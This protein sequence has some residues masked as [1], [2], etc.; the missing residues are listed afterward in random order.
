MTAVAA[1]APTARTAPPAT[2]AAVVVHYRDAASTLRCVESLRRQ[3]PSPWIVV[4]DNASPDGSGGQLAAAL[5]EVAGTVVLHAPHNGGFG[6][7]CNRGIAAALERLPTL[8]HV[9]LL[10]PD[11][12]L[13]DGA[14]ATLQATQRRRDADVVGCRVVDA[15]RAP[16][17]ENGRIPRWTLAGFHAPADARQEHPTAFVTGA[18]MLLA[19]RTLRAGLRFDER[20]FLYC[21]DAD[22]C[23]QV[24]A[25]GGSVWLTRAARAV[26]IG[27]GS[28]P[29]EAVLGELSASRLY[30]LTRAKALFARRWLNP[31][32]RACFLATAFVA[33]P[34]L[35][36]AL[37]RSTRFLAP[38]WRGLRDGLAAPRRS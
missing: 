29:G 37:A 16:W 22:L 11:A 15:E 9:L 23:E 4:V 28:Q 13:D 14:L 27:G 18:C 26:H 38:Y 31:L 19:G 2:C 6:A 21:E 24:R 20:Y 10:N 35:G 32:Q 7:G 33:K 12:E 8:E 30:W 34:L 36:L 3:Q 25:R 17:F 5:R 1:A